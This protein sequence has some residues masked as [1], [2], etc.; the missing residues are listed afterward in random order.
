[1]SR[2]NKQNA[3]RSLVVKASLKCTLLVITMAI[4]PLYTVESLGVAYPG[5]EVL[6]NVHVLA[7]I[8]LFAAG[9]S[10]AATILSSTPR[11]GGLLRLI[12]KALVAL[13]LLEIVSSPQGFGLIQANY[14]SAG[15]QVNLRTY[16]KLAMVVLIVN[17]IPSAVILARPESATESGRV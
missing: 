13:Y 2:G 7:V 4:L 17:A 9:I 16:A 5:L 8:G 6:R 3:A 11:M 14:G 1:M 10:A 15:I 12:E